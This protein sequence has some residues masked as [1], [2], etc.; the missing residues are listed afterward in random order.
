MNT[1]IELL[2]KRNE[3]EILSRKAADAHKAEDALRFSQAALNLAHVIATLT[4]ANKD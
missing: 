3:I 1:E 2:S 4:N